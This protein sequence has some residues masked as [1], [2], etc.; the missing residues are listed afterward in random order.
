MPTVQGLKPAVRMDTT[1][2]TVPVGS[3]RYPLCLLTNELLNNYR[4]RL[5]KQFKPLR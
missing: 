4:S 1:A 2:T 5:F 3:S